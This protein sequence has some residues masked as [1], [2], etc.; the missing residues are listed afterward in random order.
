VER[1]EGLSPVFASLTRLE[2]AALD[3][4]AFL[5]YT[6][7]AEIAKV[8]SAGPQPTVETNRQERQDAK[9]EGEM[10]KCEQR[11]RQDPD[12]EN[13]Q[14]AICS[15]QSPLDLVLGFLGHHFDPLVLN[16]FRWHAGLERNV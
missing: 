4:L 13:L 1:S 15:L 2:P 16:S 12:P 10:T 3:T 6:P 9:G 7:A 14:S 11:R 8:F 5:L